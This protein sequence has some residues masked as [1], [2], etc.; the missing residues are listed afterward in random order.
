[1]LAHCTSSPNVRRRSLAGIVLCSL[2]A[3]GACERQA[4]SPS[5]E[6]ATRFLEEAQTCLALRDAI[7]VMATNPKASAARSA[8]LRIER[9]GL[10]NSPLDRAAA[11]YDLVQVV[12]RVQHPEWLAVLECLALHPEP[13]AA[14]IGGRPQSLFYAR[15]AR[16]ALLQQTGRSPSGDACKRLDSK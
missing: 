5:A 7:Q 2:V 4:P 6:D 12:S 3:L 1:M 14:A 15:R 16:A 10:C 8:L 11:L 9:A 13:D